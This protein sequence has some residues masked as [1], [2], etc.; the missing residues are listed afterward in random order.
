MPTH[1]PTRLHGRIALVTGAAQGIGA[2][3]ARQLSSEGAAVIATDIQEQKV[4]EFAK[5]LGILGLHHDVTDESQWQ[6]T[7]RLIESTYGCL[8]ILVNNAGYTLQK[9]FWECSLD[10]FRSHFRVN[11]ESCFLGGKHLYPLLLHGAE[12]SGRYT[13]IVHIASTA[14][15]SGPPMQMAY[16]A[17]K[18]A[19]ISINKSMA[20]EFARTGKKIRSNAVVVGG[21]ETE[22]MTQWLDAAYRMKFFG[23]KTKGEAWDALVQ[24]MPMKRFGTPEEIADAVLYLVS[25]EASYVNGAEIRVD[26][27]AGT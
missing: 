25:D 23:D 18:A 14:G 4:K 19:V 26:G 20:S 6:E 2:A 16:N 22:L 27:A 9:P 8:D 17:S 13:S 5:T 3:I 11:A 15:Y 24:G 1:S 21:V 7:A 10:E 12:H